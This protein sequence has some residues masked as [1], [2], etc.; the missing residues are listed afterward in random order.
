LRSMRTALPL[1]LAVGAAALAPGVADAKAPAPAQAAG[2]DVVTLTYPSLVKTRVARTKR[3]L[4]R[5]VRKIENDQSVE[6]ATTFKVVRRQMAAAWRGAK[7]VIR[8]TPPP[9][10]VDDAFHPRARNS[11]PAIAP[12]IAAPADVAFL[13]LKLQHKVAANV[14]QLIDGSHGTGL[15]ALATTL[16]FTNDRRDQALQYILSVAPPPPP[17]DD[18]VDAKVHARAADE[19][20]ADTFDTVMPNLVPQLQD[21]TQAIEG[22]KSDATDLTAGGRRL[23]NDAETQIGA[24]TAFVNL[25]WPPVP[26][27]D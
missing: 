2:G 4:D 14:I 1:A 3:A 7:Y 15:N 5:A 12:T 26:V 24:S 23:L 9:V 13:A 10:V 16:N 18:A 19:P 22:L 21:E 25:H 6:A 17:P 8:T 11:G 27:D 20:V